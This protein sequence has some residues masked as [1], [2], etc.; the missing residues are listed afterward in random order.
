MAK[1]TIDMWRKRLASLIPGRSDDVKS[2]HTHKDVPP[3]VVR[4]RQN[5]GFT[6]TL[7][8]LI[9]ALFGG[10][11]WVVEHDISL[12]K[13]VPAEELQ[14]E[15]NKIPESTRACAIKAAQ[16]HINTTYSEVTYRALGKIKEQCK[17][18]HVPTTSR[19][20]QMKA[21]SALGADSK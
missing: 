15:F 19:Q 13:T 6:M 9:A 17:K 12:A 1:P 20:D 3:A 10:L 14:A 11:G 8:T 18:S 4:R 16:T 21:L 2:A 5:L 7:L